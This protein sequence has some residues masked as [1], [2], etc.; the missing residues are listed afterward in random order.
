MCLC[1]ILFSNKL[2]RYYT[3]FTTLSVDQRLENHLTNYY[4]NKFT[5]KAKDW[6]VFLEIKCPNAD[7]ARKVEAH[8]K[9]MK[10]KR[11]IENLKKYPEIVEN[12]ILK[13]DDK[14]C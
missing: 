8:I 3:G 1:Y 9:R 11:Y 10:S 6:I 7:T 13:Y 5:S 14:H 4:D 12:L 2:N